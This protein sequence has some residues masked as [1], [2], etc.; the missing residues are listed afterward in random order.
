MKILFVL[1]NFYPKIG[2]VETLFKNLT[3]ELSS[4]GHHIT[5][6]TNRSPGDTLIP[7]EKVNDYLDIVRVPFINRYL[8]TFLAWLPA[9]FLAKGKD[10]IHTT[11]Y[12][13]AIPSYITALLMR[14]KSVITFH[15]VWGKLWFELPFFSKSS[16]RLHYWFE[17][18]ILK[19]P[20]QK[21]IAVSDYTKQQLI[22]NGVDPKKVH[23][24]Y[25]GIEYK[26]HLRSK[27]SVNTPHIFLYF[28]RLGISKGLDI[29][30]Q[31]ASIISADFQLHLIVPDSDPRFLKTIK[32]LAH[33][34]KID[35]KII[36]HHN[37]PKAELID[38]V[39]NADTVI[40]PSYS[41]GFCFTAVETISL[42]T[43]IIASKNGALSEVISGTHL[44]FDPFN[45]QELSIQMKKAMA[46]EYVQSE[47]KKY[48]LEDSIEG[49]LSFYKSIFSQM[50]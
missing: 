47:V 44:F 17:Q 43:P 22:K 16:L 49:Y 5:I 24:I 7:R 30:L 46:G 39:K 48:E 41:E 2:G 10:L 29:L 13:A 11:S 14:K 9:L 40:V 25:N 19:I 42:G 18:I 4:K 34:L 35:T 26:V 38:R 31:A 33:N 15:E 8:F 32:E 50:D 36:F 27:K 12:N 37:L 45:A 20:F 1:E 23:R 21:F 6:L 3:D 28:G